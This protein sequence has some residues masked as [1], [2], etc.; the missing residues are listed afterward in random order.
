MEISPV[1]FSHNENKFDAELKLSQRSFYWTDKSQIWD[2]NNCSVSWIKKSEEEV[3]IVIR[4]SKSVYSDYRN[5]T[6]KVKYMLGFDVRAADIECPMNGEYMEPLDNIEKKYG[7]SRLRWVFKLH[8]HYWIWQWAEEGNEIQNS[9]VHRIY[10]GIKKTLSEPISSR[11]DIFKDP[12][13]PTGDN[14]NNRVIPVIY[15]AAI[16]SWKNFVREVHCHK[17]NDSEYEITILF[18]N[19]H[20]RKHSGLDLIY[21]L[22]RY[23]RYGRV[24]DIETFRILLEKGEAVKFRFDGIYSSEYGVDH[25]DVH[26]DKPVNGKVPVH[27]IKYYFNNENHPIVFINTANH[28]MSYHDTNHRLWKWEYVPWEKD[29]AIIYDEKPRDKVDRFFWP[30]Q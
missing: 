24:T 3:R 7:A 18:E 23:L 11:K 30:R 14:N 17:V 22:Y 20:L 6:V 26:E 1:W 13:G 2:W 25:D 5:K 29:S 8:K 19:E 15:Q 16:D 12:E 10:A 9:T 28:A 27:K 4:S 21:R